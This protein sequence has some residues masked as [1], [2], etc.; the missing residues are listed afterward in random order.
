MRIKVSF[1]VSPG[2]RNHKAIREA[3]LLDLGG[4]G[5]EQRIVAAAE[6]AK[7]ADQEVFVSRSYGAAGRF[8][9]W[10][11]DR[12]AGDRMERRKRLAAVLGRARALLRGRS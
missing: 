12:G 8:S 9:V 5:F 7:D 4:N 2:S 6:Q 10:V 3:I 11:V 1:P